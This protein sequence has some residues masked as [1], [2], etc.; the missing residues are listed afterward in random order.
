MIE[1]SVVKSWFESLEAQI[2][3]ATFTNISIYN[4]YIRITW[5]KLPVFVWLFVYKD[6]V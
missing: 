3:L 5:K 6:F 4:Y 1:C 2:F